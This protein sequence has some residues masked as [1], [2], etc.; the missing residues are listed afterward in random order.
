MKKNNIYE[1]NDKLWEKPDLYEKMIL[2]HKRKINR[3]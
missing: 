2:N 3:N 1:K